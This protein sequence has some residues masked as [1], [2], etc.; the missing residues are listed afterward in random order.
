MTNEDLVLKAIQ[1]RPDCNDD[2][3]SEMTGVTPRQQVNQICHRLV[4]AGVIVRT[5]GSGQKITNCLA[6]IA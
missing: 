1:A 5:K 2:E 4:K 6:N 3:L